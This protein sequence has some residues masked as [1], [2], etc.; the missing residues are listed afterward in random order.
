MWNSRL[1]HLLE[2]VILTLK[3]GF[4]IKAYKISFT[5]RLR[6]PYPVSYKGS[7]A[8]REHNRFKFKEST[9]TQRTHVVS[10]QRSKQRS[11]EKPTLFQFKGSM[12]TQ[13]TRWD[14]VPL[15]QCSFG[16]MFLWDNI[17]LGQCSFG[18]MFLWNNVPLGQCSFGTMF[19]WNNVPLEF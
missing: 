6:I 9:V 17:P 18:T 10:I 13:R 19:L 8:T 12:V 16:T 11:H 4:S 7:N 15:E 2:S 14:S 3:F 5:T 1:P